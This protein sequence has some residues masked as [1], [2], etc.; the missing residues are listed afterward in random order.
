MSLT[1][2]DPTATGTPPDARIAS[3]T[4]SIHLYSAW[5]H[6]PPGQSTWRS[7]STPDAT[8]SSSTR[9]PEELLEHLRGVLRGAGADHAGLRVG[10]LLESFVDE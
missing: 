6:S 10:R 7:H 3:R 8:S 9:A 1:V 4:S 2:P 5:N